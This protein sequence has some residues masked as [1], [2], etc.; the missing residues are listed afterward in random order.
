M[1][2]ICPNCAAKVG[3]KHVNIKRLV[4][5][6]EVCNHLFC[7]DDM[8]IN[9]LQP[10]PMSAPQP[11]KV[12]VNNRLGQL[13]LHWNWI[14]PQLFFLTLFAIFWNGFMFSMLFAAFSELPEKGI[15]A[16]LPVLV[17]P[18]T[19]VGLGLIYYVVAGYLNKTQV[20]E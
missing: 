17:L 14:N 11:Q 13:S 4:A 5:K 15:R 7:L 8:L 10:K 12:K 1:K 20:S 9:Q 16:F 6:C 19:W 2:P 3:S 18:H